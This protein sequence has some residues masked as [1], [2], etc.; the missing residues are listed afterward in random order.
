MIDDIAGELS[1]NKSFCDITAKQDK[2]I[3]FVWMPLEGISTKE[4]YSTCPLNS[5]TEQS[6]DVLRT[7]DSESALAFTDTYLVS[8]FVKIRL[9]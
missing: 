8:E 4:H 3:S 9:L 2:F 6:F 7:R 1:S 5:L